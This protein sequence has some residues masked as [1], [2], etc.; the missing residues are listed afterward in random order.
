MAKSGE[1]ETGGKPKRSDGATLSDLGI[2]GG[3]SSSWQQLA[4]VSKEQFEIAFVGD[5]RPT[6][7]G[8]IESAKPARSLGNDHNRSAKCSRLVTLTMKPRP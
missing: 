7:S 5:E 2:S 4:A 1:R 3:Q 8:I 6:A